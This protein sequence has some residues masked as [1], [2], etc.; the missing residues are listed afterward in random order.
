MYRLYLP[1]YD[2][3]YHQAILDDI[4]YVPQSNQVDLIERSFSDESVNKHSNQ[5]DLIERSFSDKSVNKYK[6]R[7]NRSNWCEFCYRDLFMHKSSI[8]TFIDNCVE[9]VNKNRFSTKYDHMLGSIIQLDE[10]ARNYLWMHNK[11]LYDKYIPNIRNMQTDAKRFI[12]EGIINQ[13]NEGTYLS[14]PDSKFKTV[15]EWLKLNNTTCSVCKYLT[16]PFHQRFYGFVTNV[17]NNVAV[18][19]CGMCND[20]D[21]IRTRIFSF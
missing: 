20:D 17:S 9:K 10:R 13:Y 5:I 12:A 19:I 21:F 1:A 2:H 15:E 8:E 18:N 3:E 4:G 7:I 11:K 14:D 6:K 16:C